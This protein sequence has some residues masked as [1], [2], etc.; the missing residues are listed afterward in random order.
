MR[1]ALRLLL[2]GLAALLCLHTAGAACAQEARLRFPNGTEV[3]A[4]AESIDLSTLRHEDVDAALEL[5]GQM[6][7]LRYTTSAPTG[8]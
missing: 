5:L 6:D 8:P 1:Q 4:S 2:F 7:K 3:A